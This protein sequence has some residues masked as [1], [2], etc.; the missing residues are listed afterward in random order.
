MG[1]DVSVRRARLFWPFAFACLLLDIIT[2]RWATRALVP[3]ERNEV[4]GDVVR[5]TLTFNQGAAFGIGLGSSSRWILLA[6]SI[7]MLAIVYRWYRSS[8][9]AQPGQVIGLALIAGGAIGNLLDR[10]LSAR[11]VVDFIDVGVAE[12]R[13]WTFNVADMGV[14]VGAALVLWSVWR[15]GAEAGR[16]S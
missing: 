16:Q 7:L 15:S 6:V 3:F 1:I 13:W 5:L 11:G 9:Q 8:G 12:T 4:L 2:K 14:S 10:L